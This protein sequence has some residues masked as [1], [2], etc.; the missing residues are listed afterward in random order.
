MTVVE[1]ID[2]GKWTNG[3]S[4]VV[5]AGARTRQ[6]RVVPNRSAPGR[7]GGGKRIAGDQ[8]LNAEFTGGW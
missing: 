2:P 1:L 5:Q 6:D 7:R 8:H 4:T 3:H